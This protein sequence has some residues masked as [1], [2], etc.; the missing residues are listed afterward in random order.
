[1]SLNLTFENMRPFVVLCSYGT[2][3]DVYSFAI[4]MCELLMLRPPYSDIVKSE[5]NENG[6]MSWDQV[7]AA[8]HKEG[9]H[10]RPTSKL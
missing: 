9:V 1:M 8:T 5:T 4:V 6:L 10:L 2:P 3:A 7:V